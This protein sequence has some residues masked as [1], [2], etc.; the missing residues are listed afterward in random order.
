[1]QPDDLVVVGRIGRPQGIRGEVTV[2]V[3]TDDP[4]VRYAAGSV[5][6]T[7]PAERGPLTVATSRDQGGRLVVLFEG[8]ADRTAAEALRDT[9]LSVP[10]ASLGDLDD[11]DEFHDFQLRGLA[12]ALPDGT[13]LGTVSDVLHLPQGDVLTI[14]RSAVAPGTPELLVPFL[15]AMVP[16]VDVAGGRLVVDPPPGLLDLTEREADA[17]DADEPV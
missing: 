17:P 9:L 15:T 7:D 6:V 8:V 13:P 10:V 11:P 16:V 12:A 2:E 1:M 5:L 14:D 3:R 4:G